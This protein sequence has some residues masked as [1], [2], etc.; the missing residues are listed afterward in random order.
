MERLRE[1]HAQSAQLGETGETDADQGT[2]RIV[3]TDETP[4]G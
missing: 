4:H 2:D 1:L 3:V